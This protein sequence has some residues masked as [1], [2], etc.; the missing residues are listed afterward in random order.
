MARSPDL[1]FPQG[2]TFNAQTFCGATTM[3]IAGANSGTF[4]AGPGAGNTYRIWWASFQMSPLVACNALLTVLYNSGTSTMLVG[5]IL[6]AAGNMA[7]IDYTAIGGLLAGNNSPIQWN[8]TTTA[9]NG[10]LLSNFLYQTE[11]V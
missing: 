10:V 3:A 8:T 11:P 6:Q 2:S 4:L 5:S 7:F 1:R 9:V